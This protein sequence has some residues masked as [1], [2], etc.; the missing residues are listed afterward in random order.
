MLIN[1]FF[2]I[3]FF[4]LIISNP[5]QLSNYCEVELK[6][7]T[8][9]YSYFLSN[10]I[11]DNS[12]IS[13]IFIKLYDKEKIGLRIYINGDEI[14]FSQPKGDEWINIPLANENNNTNILLKVNT[15]ERNSKMIFFD[16][17]KIL[18]INLTNFLSL[19]F[20]TN[21]LNKKPFPLLFDILVDRNIYFS[22]QEEKS[23][24]IMDKENAISMC[25]LDDVNSCKYIEVNSVNLIKDN[26]YRFKLNCYEDKNR[27]FFQKFKISYYMEEIYVKNNTFTINNFTQNNYLLLNVHS[28][29]NISFYMNDNSGFFHQ[30]YKM[31]ILSK[32][33]LDD[34][35]KDI[36]NIKAIQF[37]QITNGKINFMENKANDNYLIISLNNKS[38]KNKGFIL[39]FSE[40]YEINQK[41]N[42]IEI[43]KGSHALI[44]VYQAYLSTGILI[45]SQKNMKLLKEDFTNKI[46]IKNHEE[47]IIYIDSSKE[48]TILDCNFFCM[49][50]KFYNYKFILDDDIKKF[51]N[52]D[53]SDNFFI[54]KI[55]NNKNIE[56]FSYY[57][58]DIQEEY[59][60]YTK[61]YFGRANLY[62]YNKHLDSYS[63][64]QNLMNPIS[65]YDEKIYEIVNNKLLILSGTQFFNYY[66]NYA[67]FFEFYIQK[68]KDFDYIDINKEDNKYYKNTVK[69]LNR[70]KNYTIKFELNHL[71]KLDNNFLDAE[72]TFIAQLGIKYILNNKTKTIYLKGNNFTVES[73]KI[74]LIYFHEQI[75][76][77]NDKAIFEFDKFNL[78]KNCKIEI[79]NINDNDLKIAIAKDFSFENYYPMIDLKDLEILTIPAKK[80]KNLYIENY[81]DLLGTDIYESE[82]EKYLIYLFEVQK[83]NKLILLNR[84]KVE[85][86][87]QS[88]FETI[89]RF[90]KFNFGI[91]PKGNNNLILKLTNKNY[92]NYQFIK[93]SNDDIN[94]ELKMIDGN[95]TR[96]EKQKIYDNIFL[97]RKIDKDQTLINYLESKN[98]F[99]FLYDFTYYNFDNSYELR[100]YQ[101]YEIKYLNIINKNILHIEF[102]PVYSSF[103]EYYII[104]SKKD[105]INNL[106]SFSNPCY[107][108]KLI[109]NNP[110]EI[111]IKKVYYYNE[112]LITEEINI[113][114]IIQNENDEYVINII[115]NNLAYFNH[116]DIYNPVIY[117][118]RYIKENPIELK[119]FDK[120]TFNPEKDY[121]VYDHLVNEKLVIYI[122]I[123][124]NRYGKIFL[125]LTEK[126]G[127]IKKYEFYRVALQEIIVE[128]K[129]RYF[130][131]FINKED[132]KEENNLVNIYFYPFNA[133]IEEID[134]TKYKYSGCFINDK[135]SS[136]KDKY[137]AYY[138]VN[139]LKE[140][141]QVYFTFGN[142]LYSDYN[143]SPFVICKNK[144]DECINNVFS[145]NFLKG[146]EYSIYIT[147][148][149]NLSKA[150]INYCFFPI[151]HNTIQ[152]IVQE[153]YFIIDSPKILIKDKNKE[154]YF[155]IFNIKIYFILPQEIINKE[156]LLPEVKHSY[157]NN[158]DIYSF[159][160]KK[161][162]K[163]E[164]I[165][166]PE[167]N[168]KMKQIYITSKKFEVSS[169]IEIK[170]GE[171]ALILLDNIYIIQYEIKSIENYF[172]TFSSP[173][174]NMRFI[175]LDKISKNENYLFNHFEKKYL[176]I[177]KTDT[178]IY[179]N[180]KNYEPQYAFF[181][182]LNDET[183]EYFN[184]FL[185]SKNIYINKRLNT[186]Q[187]LINDL[188]N[189]YIDK[190]ETKYNLYIKKYYGQIQIYESQ[191]NLKDLSN[192]DILTKPINNLQ[193]KEV[194]FNRIIQLNKNQL[195]TG[196]L[197][198]NSLLDI[199]LEKDDDNKDI[200]LSDFK[201]RKYLKKGIEYQIHFKLNHL[202]KLEPQFNAEIKIY[203]E[204]IKIILNNK[205]QTGILKGKNFKMK[206]N[207]NVMVYFY[208]KTQKFQKRLNPKKGEIIEIN[209]KTKFSTRYSIDFGF[210]GYE[211]PN[212]LYNYYEQQLYIENIYD[213]LE[214]KLT[215]GEYLY[216][217]YD[218]EREDIF[219]IN[220]IKD[221]IIFSS[222]QFNFYLI[223]KNLTN[224]KYIIPFM[225][226]KKTRVQI[227]HCKSFLP[228]KLKIDFEDFVNSKHE[229]FGEIVN[230][231]Y[232]FHYHHKFVKI[233]FESENDFILS[234]SYKDKKDDY[235]EIKKEWGK[236]RIKNDN[237]TI[238]YIKVIN[239]KKININFNPS[240]KNSLT[241]YIIMIT[242]EENNN[243]YENMRDFCF[244]T[245]L[246]N[247]KERN[248]I[249][250]EIYDIG[251][252]DFIEIDIDISKFKYENKTF[253]INII[254]Q[255]LRF[256]NE[257]RFYEL[258]F[259]RIE[260]TI[261]TNAG[262]N[263]I[264]IIG[265]ILFLIVVI[266]YIRKSKRQ[267]TSKNRKIH[268]LKMNEE[269]LGIELNDSNEFINNKCN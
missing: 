260:K 119:F 13:Y 56:F 94:F 224:A 239:V 168:N 104:I 128:K 171:N 49:D 268:K 109:M 187:F 216:I 191:Y 158:I 27:Y 90:S 265:F 178:D 229:Y 244:I 133:M 113:S 254:S 55:T 65:Y 228:Y 142:D 126:C 150:I 120:I 33:N 246:I 87:K 145:Y 24:P 46:I 116:F 31:V 159:C 148:N 69:L 77:Y 210:E 123:D 114:K 57:F 227:N 25:I 238:N 160:L 93:C 105:N 248:F 144:N 88:Y 76:N 176:Y 195:I 181:S 66:I 247:Q 207:N 225:N 72:V 255:E 118:E 230:L 97:Q 9:E 157:L 54:R 50:S 220:Y 10:L 111:C 8:S 156:K 190:F 122:D 130:L 267:V 1:F 257:L 167:E 20:N 154:F 241:K 115:S 174:K 245:K 141:N 34:F 84:N 249:T 223:K 101:N 131:E 140:D 185:E 129:G 18:S 175:S 53:K 237:L 261:D 177:D 48:N 68:M 212:M 3:I 91:I 253:I 85:I 78:G 243:T 266:I 43:K 172:Q 134:L 173:V 35:I 67:T 135:L 21:Q 98:E 179:I 149:D 86:S 44:Y 7:G 40:I 16:S 194:I 42:S 32:E 206:T 163:Y 22:I 62:K 92:I 250:E 232:D 180:K 236:N 146:K 15:Q 61:K 73:N 188:F 99:L 226:R 217:Y 107:L 14:Y 59:F 218:D 47:S 36:N 58:F 222:Y 23:F 2:V 12:K 80:T 45:S 264:I 137:L 60:I 17:S 112:D 103:S 75:E 166:I 151:F 155:D 211:P 11:P 147:L 51:L 125:I 169:Q 165:L 213:K 258:K 52:E 221:D 186:D 138:K 204:N 28:F 215:Q 5:I 240:Y 252:N 29:Q 74:A 96:N 106:Y 256:E 64:V 4:G 214:I 234:F 201:N 82:G 102:T 79:T 108:A 198:T 197:S 203:N 233:L 110:K 192:I 182:I 39:F 6:K 161:N 251:E 183:I 153:G 95:V 143:Y 208:P 38:K 162:R 30:Y 269:S 70:K 170:S 262:K 37:K 152:N 89:T 164:M 100:R 132:L 63:K 199:Y 19:N 184:N 219:E 209:H 136:Y 200:Y 189:L 196:Y 193:K 124:L 202:I 205:N 259:F 26:K 127:I 83:D 235:I 242:P 81:Y 231:T 121:F 41:N 71:V 263:I 139:N 117:N